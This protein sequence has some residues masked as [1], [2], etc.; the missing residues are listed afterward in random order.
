MRLRLSLLLLLVV[1]FVM[2]PFAYL[3]GDAI[4]RLATQ[5]YEKQLHE[6]L[7]A[8]KHLLDVFE[9]T[10][11]LSANQQRKGFEAKYQ[12]S[13]RLHPER[14]F[15]GANYVAPILTLNG[16]PLNEDTSKIRH[17]TDMT[18]GTAATLFARVEDGFQRIATTLRQQDGSLATGTRL[19]QDHPAL[20]K[21]RGGEPY[22]GY[23][24]LFDKYFMTHYTPIFDDTGAVVGALF[25]GIDLTSSLS[26]LLARISKIKVGSNGYV[27]I[28]DTYPG[29]DFGKLLVHPQLVGRNFLRDRD[30]DITPVVETLLRQRHGIVEY[31]W[32]NAPQAAPET[33]IAVLDEH[34][35]LS[36]AIAVV[37]DQAQIRELVRLGE[38]YLLA[39]IMTVSLTLLVLLNLAISRL[40]IRP[41]LKARRAL[42]RSET[43]F[44]TIFDLT[45]NWI[46]WLNA[47]RSFRFS[48]RACLAIT[49]YPAS[50]FQQDP[51]LFLRL[52]HPDD[53]GRME[54]FL[55]ASLAT[56]DS[57]EKSTR[58]DY[59]LIDRAGKVKHLHQTNRPI[60]GEQGNQLG[61]CGAILDLTR[62]KEHES[63]LLRQSRHALVGEMISNIAHQWRQPINAIGLIAQNMKYDAADGV[64]TKELIDDYT[65]RIFGL[66]A[67][68]SDTID[69]FRSF[70]QSGKQMAV[71]RVADAVDQALGIVAASLA[72]HGIQV[73]WQR[74]PTLEAYG[75]PKEL[76]QVLLN[77]L[78]NAKEAI[79][80]SAA[81]P[82][83]IGISACRQDG[84]IQLTVADNGGGIPPEALPNIFSA[85][86]T[87]K[88]NGTGLGLFMSLKIMEHMGGGI[89]VRNH[90][91]G[92]EF[93]LSIPAHGN[94]AAS[95]AQPA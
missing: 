16:K 45:D 94:A 30:P 28:V 42:Q 13:F 47:D 64:L 62:E 84:H 52:I 18:G 74:D 87:T 76:A 93:E 48:S 68:M 53:R 14:Q 31:A 51:A 7:A 20:A 46:F 83:R 9:D 61:L 71:F 29:H 27:S 3:G 75:Y 81:A 40:I 24:R 32:K 38:N 17:F 88:K 15:T 43:Q 86:Y 67:H 69:E 23:A 5:D 37:G 39:A 95:D 2:V 59:R 11:I 56:W 49:G 33:K 73:E 21:L 44:R 91:G 77:L 66:V 72:S 78:G 8:I 36:W 10:L 60:V 90:D 50:D 6:S 4:K 19:E 58:I 1:A 22:Q 80:E 55:A 79:V 92:A 89:Q 25:V 34:R 12:G 57:D 54:E 85:N 41:Q 65:G 35:G 82:G 26:A 70:F 63:I